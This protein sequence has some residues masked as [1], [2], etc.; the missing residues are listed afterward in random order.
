MTKPESDDAP[1]H[2]ALEQLHGGCV[3]Q[4]MRGDPLAPEGGAA[5]SHGGNVLGD[6]TLD[7]ILAQASTARAGKDRLV[8]TRG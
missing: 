5:L 6:E 3:P 7:S 2:A 1:V 8:E 4:G